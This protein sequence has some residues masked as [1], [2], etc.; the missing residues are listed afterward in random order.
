ILEIQLQTPLRIYSSEGKL[1]AE[2]G[3]KKRTPMEYNQIPQT[4]IQAILAAEDA[5]FFSHHGVD[6]KGLSRAALALASTG[7]IQGGG[8]TIT[9]QVAKNYFLSRE[10]TFLR[11]FNE[12][13]LALELE[14][15]LPKARILELYVNKIYLGHR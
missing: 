10:Q 9:M 2:F 13:L 11:K 8:S 7:E 1:I 15:Q 6:I 4:F 14:R 12:I 5:R 3:E